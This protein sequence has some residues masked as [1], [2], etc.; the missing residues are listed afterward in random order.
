MA[1][2]ILTNGTT[3]FRACYRACIPVDC[4]T[5]G[6]GC[7]MR[8]CWTRSPNRMCRR[9]KKCWRVKR[10]LGAAQIH[11]AGGRGKREQSR[12][13][14]PDALVQAVSVLR[15]ADP[16]FQSHSRWGA[17]K[18]G[19]SEFADVRKPRCRCHHCADIGRPLRSVAVAVLRRESAGVVR[20]SVYATGGIWNENG[21]R[22]VC[23]AHRKTC[24]DAFGS[25]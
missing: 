13:M 6:T 20:G 4:M 17:G 15:H 1:D 5:T 12:R 25:R 3:L 8:C 16:F 11:L 21:T 2:P 19:I 14:Q 23:T 9:Q 22:S 10:P 7:P 18:G 24:C